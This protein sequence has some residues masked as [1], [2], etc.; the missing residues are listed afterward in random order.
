M[1]LVFP[2]LIENITKIQWSSRQQEGVWEAVLPCV[3]WVSAVH[4]MCH[5]GEKEWPPI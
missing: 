1:T 4:G 2:I 5:N 3:S